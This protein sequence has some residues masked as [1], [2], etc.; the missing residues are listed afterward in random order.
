[1]RFERERE[2]KGNS[3]DFG[4]SDWKDRVSI[5]KMGKTGKGRI[6]WE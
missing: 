3:K 5:A 1:M 2:A 4:L 6:G